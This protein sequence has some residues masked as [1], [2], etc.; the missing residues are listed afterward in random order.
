MPIGKTA[1]RPRCRRQR[2]RNRNRNRNVR[3]LSLS[4]GAIAHPRYRT[5]AYAAPTEICCISSE[6]AAGGRSKRR[7]YSIKLL[8]GAKL[9]QFRIHNSEFRIIMTFAFGFETSSSIYTMA[10]QGKIC[11]KSFDL[12]FIVSDFHQKTDNTFRQNPTK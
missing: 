9:P 6:Y 10:V 11:S 2:E 5:G 7:P 4:A 12:Y 8:C 3:K 1:S